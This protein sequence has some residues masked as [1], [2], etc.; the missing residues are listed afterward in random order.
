MRS[1]HTLIR[2]ACVK[3][4]FCASLAG[5]KRHR[6]GLPPAST[7]G[8]PQYATPAN[9]G[10]LAEGPQRAAP[11]RRHRQHPGQDDPEPH[12]PQ[13]CRQHPISVSEFAAGVKTP[14]CLYPACS[15]AC[16]LIILS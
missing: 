14:A 2:V 5:D 7:H 12:Q 15:C 16:L 11:L 3:G 10:L 9:A 8:L 1:S 4:H 6:A 13:S